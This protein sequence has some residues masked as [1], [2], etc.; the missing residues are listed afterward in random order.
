MVGEIHQDISV[1]NDFT[2][3]TM[4]YAQKFEKGNY[5]T[6]KYPSQAGYSDANYYIKIEKVDNDVDIKLLTNNGINK[7]DTIFFEDCSKPKYI[8]INNFYIS[9]NF[10]FITKIHS[11]SYSAKY[12]AKNYIENENE[13]INNNLESFNL[14]NILKFP[15]SFKLNIVELTCTNPGYITLLYS[16]VSS[17]SSNYP[18]FGYG[19]AITNAYS[20]DMTIY[21][22][23]KAGN[24]YFQ[25]FYIYNC[26]IIDMSALGLG[27]HSNCKDFST[28][29]YFSQSYYQLLFNNNNQDYWIIFVENV[30]SIQDEYSMQSLPNQEYIFNYQQRNII[31]VKNTNEKYIKIKSSVPQFYWTLEFSLENDVKYLPDYLT[32]SSKFENSDTLYILNPYFSEKKITDYYWFIIIKAQP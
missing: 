5:V 7:I 6:L 11:G 23:S 14:N 25:V 18:S 21:Y 29:K 31:A 3:T 22:N 17:P 10:N 1:V 20:K 8:I 4:A 13:L 28:N 16:V 30:P 32:C 24:Y 19:S 12:K 2:T 15:E 27:Y 26:P 9:S